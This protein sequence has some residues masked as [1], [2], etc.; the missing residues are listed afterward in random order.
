MELMFQ[1][2]VRIKERAAVREVEGLGTEGQ[3]SVL[4]DWG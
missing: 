3:N 2:I 1:R 4:M